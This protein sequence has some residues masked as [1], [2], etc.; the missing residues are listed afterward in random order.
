[1]SKTSSRDKQKKISK[2]KQSLQAHFFAEL[3]YLMKVPNWEDADQKTAWLML[4]IAQREEQGYLDTKD[5]KKFPCPALR[6]IDTLWVKYSEGRFG[7]SVQK[8]ILDGILAASAQ[9]NRSYTELTSAEWSEFGEKVGW[10]QKQKGEK[11]GEWLDYRSSYTF[12]PKRSAKSFAKGQKPSELGKLW[13]NEEVVYYGGGRYFFSL[14]A[15][16]RL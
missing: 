4:N 16:C 3:N 14:T 2:V 13:G 1:L 12:N 5:I 9:P 15:P 8:R 6:T 7:F 11:E 10:K